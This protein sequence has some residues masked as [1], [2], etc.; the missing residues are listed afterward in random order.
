MKIR[1]FTLSAAASDFSDVSVSKVENFSGKATVTASEVRWRQVE[2]VA[3]K[4]AINDSK[5]NL[6]ITIDVNP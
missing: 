5:S 4:Q 6:R 3:K 2:A 1:F